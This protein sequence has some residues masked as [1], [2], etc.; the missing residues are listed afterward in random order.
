[1]KVK[2]QICGNEIEKDLAFAIKKNG[3]TFY[4]CSETEYC[5]N[6]K[7]I[8]QRIQIIDIYSY[9][10]NDTAKSTYSLL[11]KEFNFNIKCL[12][13]EKV[14]YFVIKNK[15]KIKR[16]IKTKEKEY[17]SEFTLF[18]KI[19]YITAIIKK[20]LEKEEEGITQP[21]FIPA[22]NIKE[23]IDINIYEQKNKYTGK[24]RA[25]SDLED[26]YGESE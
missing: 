7:Q 16:T 14:Y 17:G 26:M 24:R 9:C 1:M 23:D 10:L 3:R 13:I 11:Q 21:D 4:F 12:G 22:L 8:K 2:C 6:Q 18:N 25:L 20:Q 15:E 19:K 5:N